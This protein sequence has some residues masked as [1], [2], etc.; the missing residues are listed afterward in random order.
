[1]E[2]IRSQSIRNS[3]FNVYILSGQFGSGKTSIAYIIALSAN[4]DHKDENGNPCLKCEK[5]REILSNGLDFWEIDGADNSS[6]EDIRK[7]KEYVGFLPTRQ[8]WK[9]IIIDKVHML[10][11]SAF[12]CLLKLLE[13][14][15]AYVI[16][17]LLSLIHI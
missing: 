6:V 13:N 1:M 8:R 5:C 10:S 16:I 9:V 14:P 2:N 4:C 12:N 7:L 3:W 17:I 15:P 11:K